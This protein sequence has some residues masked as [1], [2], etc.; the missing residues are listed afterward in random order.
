MT[1]IR[2]L[3]RKAGMMTKKSNATDEEPHESPP[4]SATTSNYFKFSTDDLPARERLPY[5]HEVWGRH[6]TG[7]KTTLLTDEPFH[8]AG[9]LV[10]LPGLRLLRSQ[11]VAQTME[12]TRSLLNDGNDGVLLVVSLA[13]PLV[14]RQRDRE[15]SLVPGEAMFA[16]CAETGAA[17]Y[18]ERGQCMTLRIPSAKFKRMVPDIEDRTLRRID[19][20]TPALHLLKSYVRT[21]E[22]RATTPA[23][24]ETFV[25]HMHDLLALVA[26]ASGDA[27]RMAAR[28]GGRAAL[29]ALIR[30]E[31]ERGFA[32]IGFCLPT[33]AQRLGMSP[34]KVQMLL[35][36]A[37]SSFVREVTQRR[38]Q[39]AQELLQ[40]ARH[41]H[42]SII[43]IAYECGFGSP[44]HFYRLFRRYYDATPRDWRHEQM[45]HLSPSGV[46]HH[47]P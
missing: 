45:A 14:G 32:K 34:R 42:L 29:L 8:Y 12:R 18:P 2:V 40:S 20:H 41:R 26:G 21:W 7:M 15:V 19:Q 11:S 17:G 38:L 30:G 13:G 37:G 33:L 6:I 22:R 36:E 16:S 5:W 31:I 28:G 9:T 4:P 46:T 1:P 25:S 44:A 47:P 23:L 10:S 24:Q 35:E 3:A 43:E 39:R 27:A